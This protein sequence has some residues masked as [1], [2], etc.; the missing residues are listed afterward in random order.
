LVTADCVVFG[1]AKGGT[2]AV[3]CAVNSSSSLRWPVP[4]TI[5]GTLL[6]ACGEGSY[7]FIAEGIS[8]GSDAV[9]VI[10]CLAGFGVRRSVVV[11]FIGYEYLGVRD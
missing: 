11:L 7:P 4:V 3:G 10:G 9:G 6:A 5:I 2:V 1:W 8:T